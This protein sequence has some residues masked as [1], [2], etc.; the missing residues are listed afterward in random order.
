MIIAKYMVMPEFRYLPKDYIPDDP[1]GRKVFDAV[2][3]KKDS[4]I[5][6][7]LVEFKMNADKSGAKDCTS[8]REFFDGMISDGVIR[9]RNALMMEEGV[10]DLFIKYVENAPIRPFY[11]EYLRERGEHVAEILELFDRKWLYTSATLKR[12]EIMLDHMGIHDMFDEIIAYEDRRPKSD[13]KSFKKLVRLLGNSAIFLDDR[14]E[15][16]EFARDAGLR[17][18]HSAEYCSGAVEMLCQEKHLPCIR[19]FSELRPYAEKDFPI[20]EEKR[21]QE[22]VWR[23]LKRHVRHLIRKKRTHDG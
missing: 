21:R 17:A 11:A 8:R 12:A 13:P 9:S 20:D 10:Y 7:W 18:F 19:S 16:V 14:V 3:P 2:R 1:T 15:S 5:Y 4:R 22:H 23:D 6:N